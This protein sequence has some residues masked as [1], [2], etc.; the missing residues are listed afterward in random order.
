MNKIL[1]DTNILVYSIDQDSKYHRASSSLL[2]SENK[3]FIA[4]KCLSE[5][6]AVVTRA[7]VVSLSASEALQ[8]VRWF[9]ENFTIL[10]PEHNSLSTLMQ[11]SEKYQPR[12]LKI[13]DFEI[14]SIGLAHKIKRLATFNKKDFAAVEEI[15]LVE[16]TG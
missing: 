4:A 16:L 10:F 7:P 14:I 15:E 8:M 12:G 6:Y 11:L 9:S 1:V 13:H 2:T 3:I 5:F